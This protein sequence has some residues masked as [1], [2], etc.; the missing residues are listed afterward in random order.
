MAEE[1]LVP[2]LGEGGL[3]TLFTPCQHRCNVLLDILIS[4]L[5]IPLFQI[6]VTVK[7]AKEK[8]LSQIEIYQD[9]ERQRS[10]SSR[11]QDKKSSSHQRSGSDADPAMVGVSEDKGLP[12]TSQPPPKQEL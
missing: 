12:L 2:V 9:Q 4:R 7:V 1:R 3:S 8:L 6:E 5:F 10:S 11:T